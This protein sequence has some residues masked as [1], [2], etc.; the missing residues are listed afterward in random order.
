MKKFVLVGCT[1]V[2]STLSA[3][4]VDTTRVS[5]LS[6]AQVIT[7]RATKRTPIAYSNLDK[8]AIE[9][10]NYGQDIPLL[11]STL[12][13]V[14]ITS[15]AGN[16]VGYT[17]LRVRGTDMTRI[18]VTSNGIPMNDP[19]S[20]GL[21]WVNMGDFASSLQD[22]QVQR[23]VGT[24]TNGAGA[25]GASIN[26]L[27]DKA[28]A[29]PYANVNLGYGSFNTT[30]NTVKFGTGLLNNR[31]TFDAR[32]SYLASDG[33]RDRA[34]TQLG[35]YFMQGAYFNGGTML[36]L[37]AFGGKEKTY[38]A[39]DG[40]SREQLTTDRKF[41]PNGDMGNG[42]YYKDQNDVYFQQH[43][44]ALLS[45]KLAERWALSAALHYTH[46][47][48]YYEEYKKNR[49]F[50]DYALANYDLNGT[51]IKRSD[52]VRRKHLYNHF[53]GAIASV[54]YKD[55]AWDIT[56]GGGLNQYDNDHYGNVLWVKNYV[57]QLAP[58]HE[59][60]R[61]NGKKFDGN[62]YLRANYAPSSAFNL[63][64]DLQYRHIGY[65]LDGTSDKNPTLN[66]DEKFNFFNPKFGAVWNV[67]QGQQAYASMSV[68]H[69]EPTNNNYTESYTGVAPKAERLFDYELGYRITGR[70][71]EAA[72]NGYWMQYRNQFVLNGQYNEI[73]EA[74]SENVKDSYRAGIELSGAWKPCPAFQWE[75]NLTLSTNRIKDH[76]AYLYD[77]DYN[78]YLLP[79]GNTTISFSP[80]ATFNNI[81]HYRHKGFAASLTSQYVSR[82]YLDNMKMKENSLDAYFVSH[83]NA[84][85]SFKMRG[86]KEVTIGATVYNLFN[87]KYETNG[88]SMTY[89]A[90][91]TPA[92]DIIT[93]SDPRFYPMAGTNVMF[94]LGLKF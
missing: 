10:V 93:G 45:Q 1:A 24:S 63:Y 85:Y 31:W 73:G 52:L 2:A 8:A 4:G 89:V 36:K 17:S 46:G 22:L 35:S 88:Y 32:M 59:Y 49:K 47:R 51:T 42:Q 67:A 15:D 50:A 83:L 91:K 56:F 70:K 64:A 81:F 94:N 9:R 68:A 62:T 65:T 25:F 33:Y 41:N 14:V 58:N 92:G 26:M 23:G 86:V 84:S 39:W 13:S 19:E 11:L 27:T 37:I 28:S 29:E 77:G 74:V 5:H 61:Y 6:E 69:R 43:A 3:Q 40:I 90:G 18:N 21:Y 80:S 44:Q 78:E 82:Q 79:V 20:H 72:V 30:K 38:H 48:G 16:G 75:A 34:N 66:T 87:E 60:Y 76:V 55:A 53:G 12:P 7:N 57:G 71:F 54:N